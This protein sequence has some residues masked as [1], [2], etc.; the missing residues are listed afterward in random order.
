MNEQQ[1]T[2]TYGV[3]SMEKLEVAIDL[4][5][6]KEN[7]VFTD[8]TELAD[9]INTSFG[10]EVTGQDILDYYESVYYIESLD[11]QLHYKLVV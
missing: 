10:Y 9:K 7:K 11:R 6:A 5:H 2:S 4:I 3:L 1:R 8:Y